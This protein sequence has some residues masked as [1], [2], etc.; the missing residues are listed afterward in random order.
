MPTIETTDPEQ[1]THYEDRIR[2]A[3]RLLATIPGAWV[4]LS[5]LRDQVGGYRE[6]VDAALRQ[7]SRAQDVNIVPESNQKTLTDYDRECAIRIGRQD[8]HLIAIG[9]R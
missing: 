6:Y 3:Y 1:I 9:I 2:T 8:R 4:I 7:L 5:R